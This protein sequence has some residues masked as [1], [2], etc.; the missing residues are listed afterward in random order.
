MKRK[1]L[2]ERPK[3]EIHGEMMVE[4]TKLSVAL[5]GR[6]DKTD[7]PVNKKLARRANQ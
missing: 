6:F 7:A 1:R 5:D 3:V 2:N 4:A